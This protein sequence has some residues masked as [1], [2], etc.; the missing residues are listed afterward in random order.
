MSLWRP[1]HCTEAR[2]LGAMGVPMNTGRRCL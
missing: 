2:G 1:N